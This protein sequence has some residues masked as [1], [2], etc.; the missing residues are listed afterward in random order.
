[1]GPTPPADLL[2]SGKLLLKELMEAEGFLKLPLLFAGLLT[3]FNR[4][5]SI[6]PPSRTRLSPSSSSE[7]FLSS[8]YLLFSRAT[9]EGTCGR[10][11]ESIVIF[12]V[13]VPLFM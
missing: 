7:V 5:R 13:G 6:S 10:L 9:D 3:L 8:D 2:A 1:V 4:L 11:L 12:V